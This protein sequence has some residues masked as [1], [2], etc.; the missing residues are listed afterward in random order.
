MHIPPPIFSPPLGLR[1]R[2]VQTIFSSVGPRRL[3]LRR[4][5]KRLR[6][7][8]QPLILDAGE[9]VRLLSYLNKPH[10]ETSKP[11]LVILIHGWEGSEESSYMLSASARLLDAGYAVLRL[12]MRDH[13][14]SHHLN[15]EAFNST[16]LD[17]VIQAIQGVQSQQRYERYHLAGFSLG[18]N[19]SLR[20][21]ASEQSKGLKLRSVSA[22]C[23]VVH[24]EE[25]NT[26]LVQ[27][28][29]WLYDAYFVRKWKRSLRRKSELFPH[30]FALEDFVHLDSLDAMNKALIPKYTEFRALDDYFDAYA[31]VD[32]RLKDPICP[33]YLHF[34]E[35]DMIIPVTGV[36]RI[37]PHPSLQVEVT[38]HGGHCGYLS[39]W[40]FDSWQ[41]ER[42]LQI[43]AHHDH[44]PE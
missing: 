40:R 34:A 1:N 18:G 33:C 30:R 13:G 29:N 5:K 42:L 23:P 15:E 32:D 6:Q 9:G 2:H 14:A 8:A 24:A 11:S 12:N 17:E 35:D 16:L 38:R 3:R 36:D 20:V 39:N 25:A 27:R 26:A 31:I 41:D 37:Q 22:F 44:E 4:I 19:F 10:L 21:A 43:I 7:H 28:R